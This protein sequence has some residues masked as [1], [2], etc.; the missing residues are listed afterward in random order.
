MVLTTK[1]FNSSQDATLRLE[2]QVQVFGPYLPQVSVVDVGKTAVVEEC[3][4]G[5]L[6]FRM[7]DQ[8]QH[9]V[10]LVD[11]KCGTHATF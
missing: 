6:F 4:V 11:G 1:R 8:D 5:L 9:S 7:I 10:P 3:D 2:R